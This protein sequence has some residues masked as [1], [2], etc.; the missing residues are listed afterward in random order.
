MAAIPLSQLLTPFLKLSNNGHAELLMKAMGRA[1]SPAVPGS[2]PTG[3]S[4]ANAALAGLGVDTGVIRMGDGSGLSRRNWLTTRQITNLLYAAQSRP[5][6]AAWYAA[7]PIAGNPNRLIG[8]TLASRMVGTPA[9]LNLHGK[10]GT[11]SSVNALSGY[12]ND[13]AG[14]RL[15]FSAVSNNALVNVSGVLDSAGVALAS[16]GGSGTG[17]SARRLAP[18]TPHIV[19]RD[20]ADIECSWVKAC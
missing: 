7:L 14:R 13:T 3:L 2:W 16:S 18:V 12:V 10:T 4:A 9:A 20:G 6:F 11:L 17:L 19:T 5:W 15:V 8:G 1:K